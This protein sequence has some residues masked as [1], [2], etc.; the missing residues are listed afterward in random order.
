MEVYPLTIDINN[1]LGIADTSFNILEEK[2]LTNSALQTTTDQIVYYNPYYE[3]LFDNPKKII[4]DFY[5]ITDFARP[6][7]YFK[8]GCTK[9]VLLNNHSCYSWGG[10]YNST[11][12]GGW[13]DYY[14]TTGVGVY[15]LDAI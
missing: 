14:D 2:V 13:K 8:R 11:K 1:Y 12:E 15:S 6:S 4:G 5:V 10:A 7:C 3:V 9:Q